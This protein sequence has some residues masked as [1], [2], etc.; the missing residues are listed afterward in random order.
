MTPES[1]QN[2]FDVL[3]FHPM[4]TRLDQLVFVGVF[5]IMNNFLGKHSRLNND[6]SGRGHESIMT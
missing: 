2:E 1:W 4:I 3:S 5:N 6:V